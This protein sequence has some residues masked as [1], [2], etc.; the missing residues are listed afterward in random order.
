MEDPGVVSLTQ[1]NMKT[2]EDLPLCFTPTLQYPLSFLPNSKINKLKRNFF[3]FWAIDP[4]IVIPSAAHPVH[5]LPFS[6]FPFYSF[7][8]IMKTKFSLFSS[9]TL[10][11]KNGTFASTFQINNGFFLKIIFNKIFK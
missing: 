8:K 1:R 5:H 10:N 2:E 4:F 3:F 11:S 9:S 7:L 6:L